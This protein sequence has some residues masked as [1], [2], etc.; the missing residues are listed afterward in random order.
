MVDDFLSYIEKEGLIKKGDKVLLAVSGGIDSVVMAYLFYRSSIHFG[1][2]HCNFQLRDAESDKDALF[3]EALA[4]QFKKPFFIKSFDTKKYAMKNNISTQMAARE[5]RYDWFK[6]LLKKEGYSSLATAH[7]V[8]DSLETAIFNFSKGTGISGIRGILPKSSNSIRPI[9][10]TSKAQIETFANKHQLKWREDSSNQTDDYSRN[11]IRHN[12][13]PELTK[14]N[15]N[16]EFTVN[17]TLERLRDV[18]AIFKQQVER[19]KTERIHHL[20]DSTYILLHNT[21]TVKGFRTVLHEVL[22]EYGFNYA[23]TTELLKR[24]NE[25]GRLFSSND[26]SLNVDREQL[27]IVKKEEKEPDFECEIDREDDI[28]IAP[29]GTIR[30]DWKA[31]PPSTFLKN[32]NIAYFATDELYFPLKLRRWKQGD[33]FQPLGMVNKKKLSDLMIDR[34]IPLNLKKN[35]MVLESNNKIIWVVGYQP[36]DRFKIT[37]NTNS[38]CKVEFIPS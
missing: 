9:L 7:H 23:Q 8:N 1:I 17:S 3:V 5:L 15:P 26:Y 28:V 22:K 18:E 24:K 11:H 30:F 14:I 36:D 38:I 6:K 35:V 32:C 4:N 13:I 27:I 12:V 25:S 33:S 31:S 10:F 20:N 19:F 37:E 29:H 21:A 16:L 34:K 2:A